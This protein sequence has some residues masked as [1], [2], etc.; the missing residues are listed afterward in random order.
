[1]MGRTTQVKG[2]YA[3]KKREMSRSIEVSIQVI[4]YFPSRESNLKVGGIPGVVGLVGLE[5]DVF[6]EG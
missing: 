3:M 4:P 2:D 6:I 5:F 1:M